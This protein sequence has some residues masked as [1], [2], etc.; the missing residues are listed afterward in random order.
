MSLAGIDH[1]RYSGRRSRDHDRGP[2]ADGETPVLELV[3]FTA[4]VQ[5]DAY[6]NRPNLIQDYI[7]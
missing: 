3:P 5:A 2:G 1:A 4:T 7:P 6:G